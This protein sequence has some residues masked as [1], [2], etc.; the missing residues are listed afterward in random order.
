MDRQVVCDGTTR[1][2][3]GDEVF[4][5]A[6]TRDIRRVLGALRTTRRAGA[7]RDDRRRR[8]GRPAAGARDRGRTAGSRSSRPTRMRCEYLATQLPATCWC[9][10]ATAPTRTCS[11]DENVQDMDLF[12]ALTSDDEDNIMACLLAK[13]MGARR[14]LAL[15]NRARL[16][17]PG[18]G[19]ADRHRDL[20]GADGASASCWPT[21][22]AATSRPCTACAAARPRRWRRW[23]AATARPRKVVGRRIEELP[24]PAGAQ[25]GAHR[26]RP[27]RPT[28]ARPARAA[29]H[30]R[31]TTTR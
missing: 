16:C 28:A 20:A 4:V 1:I 15:I 26:A 18:A 13:R 2:E 11:S 29:G 30:H 7:P 25:I 6:A 24:L 9:C 23:C 22:G 5:L 31:R 27:A 8:Q 21:C 3:P 17:R 10:T 12:L 14:V 19:H